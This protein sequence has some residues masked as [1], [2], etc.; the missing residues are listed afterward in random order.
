MTLSVDDHDWAKR[1]LSRETM[2]RTRVALGVPP[3]AFESAEDIAPEHIGSSRVKG[4]CK[5]VLVRREP[6]VEG[7]K[8]ETKTETGYKGH[9]I[10]LERRDGDS[11]GIA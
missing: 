3:W 6:V 5:N 7:Q 11:N 1:G 9:N 10:A 2:T 4:A 8:K